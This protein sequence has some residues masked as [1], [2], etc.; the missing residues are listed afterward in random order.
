[1]VCP[2][3]QRGWKAMIGEETGA[4]LAPGTVLRERY[5]IERLI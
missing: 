2:E 5:R 3:F 4:V 1:V